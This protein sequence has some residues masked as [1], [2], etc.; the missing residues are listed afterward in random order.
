[1]SQ[2]RALLFLCE[3]KVFPI[4]RFCDKYLYLLTDTMRVF[5]EY[6]YMSVES[7]SIYLHILITSLLKRLGFWKR[8]K[9]YTSP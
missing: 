5:F 6:G 2:K 9:N 3:I 4:G 8:G 1:M 7:P